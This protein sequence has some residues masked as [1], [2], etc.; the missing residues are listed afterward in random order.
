MRVMLSSSAP[1]EAAPAEDE[2]AVAGVEV[3]VVVVVVVVAAAADESPLDEGAGLAEALAVLAVLAVP[4]VWAGSAAVRRTKAARAAAENRTDCDWDI[5]LR[6][7][8]VP[9]AGGLASI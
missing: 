9:R 8:G 1:P 6:R 7:G 5:W 2:P 4:V 3:V